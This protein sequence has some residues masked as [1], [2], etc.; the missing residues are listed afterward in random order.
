MEI[1]KIEGGE[2][3]VEKA[4]LMTVIEADTIF[5]QPGIIRLAALCGGTVRPLGV[6]APENGRMRLRRRLTKAEKEAMGI[7]EITGFAL[8]SDAGIHTINAD[9]PK[10]QIAPKK[11]KEQIAPIEPEGA[12]Q[13]KKKRIG[14]FSSRD[15]MHWEEMAE[16][17]KV[18]R[19]RELSRAAKG[20]YGALAAEVGK[21][22]FLAI[23]M[24]SERAFPPLPVFRFGEPA[25]IR[26]RSYVVFRLID[27][28]LVG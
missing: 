11:T 19:D 2:V 21:E 4:G 7:S 23:P 18:F 27:G 9:E 1:F 25:M 5:K 16:P 28:V 12:A 17:W 3:R 26:G 14:W 10:E 22:V 8:I 6:L 13:Q 24:D 15:E 20:V